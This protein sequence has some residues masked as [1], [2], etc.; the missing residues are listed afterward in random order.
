MEGLVWN[1]STRISAIAINSAQFFSD[2][3]HENLT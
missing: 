3:L 1:G 2:M